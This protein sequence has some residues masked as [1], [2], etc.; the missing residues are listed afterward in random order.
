MPTMNHFLDRPGAVI[1][2]SIVL[3]IVVGL[4]TSS[5]LGFGIFLFL[6]SVVMW[7]ARR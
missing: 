2:V 3:A 5:L 4:L 7:L 1:G 6:P